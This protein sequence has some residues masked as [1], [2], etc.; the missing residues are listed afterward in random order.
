[1]LIDYSLR[2][3]SPKKYYCASYFC[4]NQLL[5]ISL[6]NEENNTIYSK[7][8]KCQSIQSS[9]LACWKQLW[10]LL[11]VSSNIQTELEFAYRYTPIVDPSVPIVVKFYKVIGANFAECSSMILGSRQD[12]SFVSV[13]FNEPGQFYVGFSQVNQD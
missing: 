4:L 5:V 12:K 7:I 2:L 6:S 13:M 10:L 11:T 3:Q 8:Y 9:Y 1:M